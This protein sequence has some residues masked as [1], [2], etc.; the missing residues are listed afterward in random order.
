MHELTPEERARGG[1][2]SGEVRRA[3][4]DEARQLALERLADKIERATEAITKSMEAM[5]VVIPKEDEPIQVPGHSLRLRA[6]TQILDRIVGKPTQ[7]VEITGED[8]QPVQVEYRGVRLEDIL[9]HAFDAVSL[10][11]SCLHTYPSASSWRRSRAPCRSSA[12]RGDR[13]RRSSTPA[14][15]AL[16]ARLERPLRTRFRMSCGAS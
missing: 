16:S 10:G 8:E 12:A 4:R 9:D 11:H 14:S 6:A 5:V 2:L 1:R 13:R 3:Q 7:A 15:A